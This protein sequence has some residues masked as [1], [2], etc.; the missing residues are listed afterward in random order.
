[1]PPRVVIVVFVYLG[2]QY[3]PSL[4]HYI[5]CPKITPRLYGWNYLVRKQKHHPSHPHLGMS[6]IQILELVVSSQVRVSWPSIHTSASRLRYLCSTCCLMHYR[7]YLVQECYTTTTQ[8]SGTGRVVEL[9]GEVEFESLFLWEDKYLFYYRRRDLRSIGIS[10]LLFQ[11]R[12]FYNIVRDEVL[13]EDV[14]TATLEM[15]LNINFFSRDFTNLI[16][17]RQSRVIQTTMQVEKMK[18]IQISF[19]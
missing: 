2:P 19:P 16:D 9:V 7:S 17:R 1:M 8:S 18:F 3:L 5:A 10:T 12:K 11:C 4:H 6:L 13:C 15:L 14:A